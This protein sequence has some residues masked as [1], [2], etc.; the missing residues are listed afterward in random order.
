[1]SAD[2]PPPCRSRFIWEWVIASCLGLGA[3]GALAGAL[4]PN[5]GEFGLAAAP[6]IAAGIRSYGPRATAAFAI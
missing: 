1:M 6:S 5:G 3:S 2:T 4:A